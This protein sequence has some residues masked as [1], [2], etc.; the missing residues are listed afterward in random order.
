MATKYWDRV[1]RVGRGRDFRGSKGRAELR[2]LA[3]AALQLKPGD[4]V[5]DIGCGSGPDLEMLRDAVGGEG[6]VLAIDASE[7]MVK[8]AKAR[9]DAAGWD[10][11]EVRHADAT[12]LTVEGFD[13][14][15]S[16]FTVSA[17]PD[18]RATLVYARAALRP[19]G[20]LYV[21]DLRLADSTPLNRVFRLAYR[22]FARWTGVDVLE[23]ARFVFDTVEVPDRLPSWPPVVAFTAIR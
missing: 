9:V 23:T 13:A 11:V 10:N 14:A 7:V 12:T 2:R 18:V 22:V 1:G 17:T 3:E 19:G 8:H 5:L 21:M 15:L 16:I 4:R 6:F 20:R